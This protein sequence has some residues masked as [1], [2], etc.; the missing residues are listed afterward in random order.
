MAK[1]P[2]V[3]RRSTRI[4]T[5]KATKAIPKSFTCNENDW[6]NY[7]RHGS[8]QANLQRSIWTVVLDDS[9]CGELDSNSPF[10]TLTTQIHGLYRPN[11]WILENFPNNTNKWRIIESALKLATQLLTS[12][13]AMVFFRRLKYGLPRKAG[14]R[15]YL[16]YFKPKDTSAQD[17]GV[18]ADLLNLAQRVKILFGVFK[19]EE[20]SAAQTH[21]VHCVSQ[22]EFGEKIFI[23]G[24]MN[25][26]P[27]D[28]GQTH[29]LIVNQAY[30]MY[31]SK[32][33][34]TLAET[35]RYVFSLAF[36]LL[37]ETA[38]AFYARNITDGKEDYVEPFYDL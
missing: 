6:N 34:L 1:I 21:A 7:L 27:P 32:S 19:P 5:A 17:A 18:R 25:K 31:A 29:Y 26:L 2:Q 12:A 13:P 33:N 30:A 15:V 9:F 20:G 10:G 37:H 24:N 11:N 23:R 14:D 3:S 28:D 36:S 35:V 4:T 22:S 38:H 8:D 16:R